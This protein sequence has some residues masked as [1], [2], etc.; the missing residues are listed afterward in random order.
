MHTIE[1]FLAQKS[2]TIIGV[3]GS[4]KKFGN[5]VL[6]E[7][8]ANGYHLFPVHPSAQSIEGVS[9]YPSLAALPEPVGGL[10][11]VVPPQQTE[12]VL[13][14]AV[15]AGITRVWMQQGASSTAAISFC[16]EHNIAAVHGECILMYLPEGPAIHR[17][18]RWLRRI[19]GRLPK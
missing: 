18:H 5:A 11:L 16:A 1:D 17:F 6:R 7:L 15:S 4:E 2:L 3:S 9:C 12:S 14:E 19:F 10:I 8:Q 13:R